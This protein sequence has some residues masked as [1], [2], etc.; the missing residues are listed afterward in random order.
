[1]AS[2]ELAR[3]ANMARRHGLKPAKRPAANTVAIDDRVKSLGAF[4][5]EFLAHTGGAIGQAVEAFVEFW[6]ARADCETVTTIRINKAAMIQNH[7]IRT[8]V[9]LDRCIMVNDEFKS[10]SCFELFINID[11]DQVQREASSRGVSQL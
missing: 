1:M 4:S 3:K 10:Q 9:S 11:V 2:I 7:N 6:I 8:I 5:V